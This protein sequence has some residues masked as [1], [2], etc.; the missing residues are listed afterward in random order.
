MPKRLLFVLLTLALVA[1]ACGS[2]TNQSSDIDTVDGE[3]DELTADAVTSID[4]DNDDTDAGGGVEMS[5]TGDKSVEGAPPPALAVGADATFTSAVTSA[6]AYQTG[7]F[8]GVF[9]MTGVDPSAPDAT[10]EMTIFGRY[11]QEAEAID[12]TIDLGTLMSSAMAAD[13]SVPAG[14]DDMFSEPLRMVVIGDESWLQWSLLSMFTGQPDAW[15]AATPEE[16]DSSSLGVGVSSGTMDPTGILSELAGADADI[17]VVGT[18][19]VRGVETTHWLATVDVESL[20][21]GLDDEE[22][23]ELEAQLGTLEGD[24][25]PVE[26][27]VGVDDGLLYRYR[28]TIASSML[29]ETAGEAV[30]TFELF[31]HG[32]PVDIAAPPADQIIDSG[33]LFG[34]FADS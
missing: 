20:A 29:D 7:R 3:A 22:R 4:D 33:A 5:R 12:V 11:D 17:T 24:T 18:E 14:F 10:V 28:V 31:D 34:A 9:A 21:G 8:E 30:V 27:W 13:P 19:T 1:A 26:L 23:A 6:A 16:L 2:A 15:M 25:V 32:Q